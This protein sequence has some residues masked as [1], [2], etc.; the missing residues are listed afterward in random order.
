MGRR[1]V[2]KMTAEQKAGRPL[3]TCVDSQATVMDPGR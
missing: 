3:E 2:V 1:G